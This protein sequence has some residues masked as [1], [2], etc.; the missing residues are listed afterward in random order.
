MKQS[1][2]IAMVL[3]L[4]LSGCFHQVVQTGRTPGTTV[5]EKP[6]TATW[7]WGLVPASPIDVTANCPGGIAT[8]ETKQSFMNGLVGALTIGIFTPR[9]VKVTCASGTAR[10]S[11]MK[12]FLVAR[13]ASQHDQSR[14]MADAIAESARSHQ[15]VLIGFQQD[16]PNT[17]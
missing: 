9:D 5:V 6:W 7:L 16:V 14:V 11:G 13:E 15:P 3:A 10:G 8:V 1:A 17:K 4:V 2:S 12:E